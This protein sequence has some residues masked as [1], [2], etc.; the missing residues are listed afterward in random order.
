MKSLLI[1]LFLITAVSAPTAFS[2]EKSLSGETTSTDKAPPHGDDGTGGNGGNG[3][4][5]GVIILDR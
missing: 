1:A 2:A 5:G 4:S 3:G